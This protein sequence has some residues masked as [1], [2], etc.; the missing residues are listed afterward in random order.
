MAGCMG[1]NREVFMSAED[2]GL[3][4]RKVLKLGVGLVLPPDQTAEGVHNN[5]II[6]ILWFTGATPSKSV[7]VSAV[8]VGR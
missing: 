6:N 8:G 7:P 3:Y 5:H 4:V 1:P 2:E